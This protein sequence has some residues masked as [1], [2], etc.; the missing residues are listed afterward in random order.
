MSPA[1]VD[2]SDQVMAFAE[3]PRK[4]AASSTN[5]LPTTKRPRTLSLHSSHTTRAD[6]TT[7]KPGRAPSTAEMARAGLR[8]SITLVLKHVNAGFDSASE[9]AME[10]FTSI[11]ETCK[12][13]SS[14]SL[15]VDTVG[16]TP[17]SLKT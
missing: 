16:L 12:M 7:P 14:C 3:N 6:G 5:E 10:S 8:R 1:P 15:S 13:V 17:V 9:E 2:D 11:V 4:R